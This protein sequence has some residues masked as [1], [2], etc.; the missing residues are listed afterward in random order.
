MK[1]SWTKLINLDTKPLNIYTEK[2][3]VKK[4]I[5]MRRR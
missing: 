2:I 1:K 3:R 5:L 4:F